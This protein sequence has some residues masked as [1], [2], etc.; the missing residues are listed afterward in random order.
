MSPDR[1]IKYLNDIRTEC[2]NIETFI[3]SITEWT[4]LKRDIKTAY[5]VVRSISIIGEAAKK[6]STEYKK[7][8]I[9]IDWKLI[10]GMRDRLV[11]DYAGIDYEIVWN[12]IKE[13]IPKLLSNI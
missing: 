9:A 4:S 8:N 5:A 7:K 3:G 12:V 2:A 6:L 1:D 11:H 10:S 13:E